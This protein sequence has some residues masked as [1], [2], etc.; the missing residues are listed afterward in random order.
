VYD[1]VGASDADGVGSSVECAPFVD[2]PNGMGYPQIAT[3]QLQAQGFS[4]SLINYGIPTATLGPT[5]QTLGNQLG[6][7]ILGNFLTNEMPFIRPNATVVTV[8]AGGNDVNTIVAALGAGLGGLDPVGYINQQVQTFKSDYSTLIAGIRS[9]AGGSVRIVVLNVPNL[10]KM[11]FLA[12]AS[13]QQQQAAQVA[14]VQMT[15]TVVN[16]LTSQNVI[17]IDMMCTDAFYNASNFSSDGFHPNDA[18]YTLIANAVVRAITS[19]SNPTP[20]ASC[21]AMTAVPNP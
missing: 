21:A 10:A 7:I 6:R 5:L 16:P 4:V 9:R 18:G 19:S 14:S 2:C 13:L 20:A 8:F 11:P 1:A 15:T 12:G 3:R 17:V